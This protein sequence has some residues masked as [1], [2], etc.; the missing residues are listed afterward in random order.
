MK[1]L[2]HSLIIL[3]AVLAVISSASF[4]GAQNTAPTDEE[5]QDMA[6]S[7]GMDPKRCAVLQNQINKI[8]A[9]AESSLKDDEKVA[10]LSELVAQSMAEMQK[11][12]SKDEEV[13]GIVNQ[14]LSLMQ[15][16]MSAARTSGAGDDKK[17]PSTA[18]EDLAKLKTM[19]HTYVQMMKLMCPKLVVPESTN[20]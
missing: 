11:E 19:T 16:I 7:M 20:K 5:V 9:V 18:A 15:G 12:A 13:A 4:L 17:V 14:Y 3:L 6:R 2:F 8:T 10:R 1:R